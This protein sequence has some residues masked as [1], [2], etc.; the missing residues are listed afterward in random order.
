M[1]DLL[2]LPLSALIERLDRIEA[3]LDHVINRPP[4]LFVSI[5]EAMPLTGCRSYSAQQR[6]F[7][8]NGIHPAGRGKYLRKDI[9]GRIAL[10]SL[11]FV[12]Q[13][14]KPKPR[15]AVEPVPDATAKA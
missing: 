4:P 7:R 8:V 3:K 1:S 5:S 11:G 15:R 12:P 13:K 10:L 6:W 2:P 14:T 9:T